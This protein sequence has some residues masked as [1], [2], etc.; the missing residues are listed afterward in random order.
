MRRACAGVAMRSNR[1]TWWSWSLRAPTARLYSVSAL[2]SLVWA[3]NTALSKAAWEASARSTV[4][5]SVTTED[6]EVPE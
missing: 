6:D 4:S 3:E 5:R 1:F 2:A